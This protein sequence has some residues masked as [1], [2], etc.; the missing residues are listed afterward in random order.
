MMTPQG[1]IVIVIYHGH[2]GGAD[3]RNQLLQFVE[4]IDQHLADVLQYRFIN[5]INEPPFL[6]AI[7]KRD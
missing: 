2:P 4:G 7:E 6:I 3:E 1:I 5:Q